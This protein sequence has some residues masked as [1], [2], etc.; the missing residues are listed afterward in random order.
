MADL[1]KGIPAPDEELKPGV[2]HS[3]GL[4]PTLNPFSEAP[5]IVERPTKTPT[6]GGNS[7]LGSGLEA[8]VADAYDTKTNLELSAVAKEACGQIAKMYIEGTEPEEIVFPKVA[9]TNVINM[10]LQEIANTPLG[11]GYGAF[12]TKVATAWA[13]FIH[14]TM[15]EHRA[16]Y[17]LESTS[18]AKLEIEI[19]DWLEGNPSFDILPD[20]RL[21]DIVIKGEADSV[22][23]SGARNCRITF[24]DKVNRNASIG[25]DAERCTFL[26]ES[27]MNS[28]QSFSSAKNLSIE[29]QGDHRNNGTI[30]P[31][32]F[33]KIKCHGQWSGFYKHRGP[34]IQHNVQ[35]GIQSSSAQ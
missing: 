8:P 15:S 12:P 35:N 5:P 13:N 1:E 34:L 21:M 31:I 14:Q 29:I 16:A 30:G 10:A 19:P 17:Q 18:L 11:L 28:M 26:F 33:S 7:I 6:L 25:D 9:D 23:A 24:K 4:D 2:L 3:T 22:I 20:L 27:D 32:A